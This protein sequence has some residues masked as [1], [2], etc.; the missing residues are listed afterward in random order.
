MSHIRL[1]K[2][3]MK[4]KVASLIYLLCWTV[5]T[6][7]VNAQITLEQL[8]E[9]TNTI[10]N[11][12]EELRRTAPSIYDFINNF[13]DGFTNLTYADIA[14]YFVSV[15]TMLYDY[16]VEAKWQLVKAH[17]KESDFDN[18]NATI[19][20]ALKF[21]DVH[22]RLVTKGDL[23]TFCK[24]KETLE[25]Y[26]EETLNS[27]QEFIGDVENKIHHSIKGEDKNSYLRFGLVLGGIVVVREVYINGYKWCCYIIACVLSFEIIK[28]HENI[29]AH[30][31]AKGILTNLRLRANK[32]E[33]VYIG[34]LSDARVMCAV[35]KPFSLKKPLNLLSKVP[36]F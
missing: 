27:L 8:A 26:F 5:F 19:F 15:V 10:F 33:K 6:P 24:G 29:N 2:G 31:T 35:G 1:C 22:V 36:N 9:F 23:E 32:L 20:R 18:I 25:T 7:H 34:A 13:A 14:V 11:A 17:F 16:G 21:L 12:R 30:H 28:V 3:K 4:L